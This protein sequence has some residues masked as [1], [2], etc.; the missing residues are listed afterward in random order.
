VEARGAEQRATDETLAYRRPV[1]Q[2]TV[3]FPRCISGVTRSDTQCDE[4]QSPMHRPGAPTFNPPG[5][6][7]QS[8]GQSV[9]LILAF[10]RLLQ[11]KT[12]FP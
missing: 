4:E 11:G 1:A 3:G 7:R 6:P 2:D 8:V 9:R 5:R 10:P 12:P